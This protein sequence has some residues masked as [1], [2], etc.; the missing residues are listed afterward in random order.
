MTEKELQFLFKKYLKRNFKPLEWYVHGNKD[1]YDFEK[2]ISKC[3]EYLNLKKSLYG[4]E[5]PNDNLKLAIILSGH[6]RKNSTLKLINQICKNENYHVFI[7]TWDNLGIKGNETSFTDKL[8]SETVLSEIK[9][10]TNL[11]EYKIENNRKWIEANQT[12]KKYFNLS[13][14]EPFI[15][16]QLYSVNTS[17]KLMDEYSKK[18]NI[19]Y[20]VV[21]KFRFDCDITDFNL[22]DKTIVDVKNNNIIFTPNLDC[23]HEH[24]D[25]G[26]SCWAC[27]NMYY[28]HDRTKV[29]IFEHTNVICDIFAY[30]SQKS[31]K[32]Y[33]D[34][35]NNYD[36]LNDSFFEENL[37]Q[38]KHINE[39]IKYIDGNYVL[40]QNNQGHIDSLYY[41]NCS[42]PER[43]LQKFL[44]DYMLVQ[45]TDVRVELVR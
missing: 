11:K 43:L 13:S 27:D 20:D 1:K 21:F 36:K 34:L 12:N 29:H 35:Y 22:S 28:V 32:D 30:G 40:D 6:I 9:K 17:Y 31:M 10:Y 24:M 37:K 4:T 5:T 44:K 2:Q 14:P 45:S 38:Y 19:E 41:Y 42:Y 8:V 16:S 7:H 33:C 18:N 23:K 26:T 39:N 3:E 25:Y 15:K